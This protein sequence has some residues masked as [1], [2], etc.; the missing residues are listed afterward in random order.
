M[1]CLAREER[2]THLAP[3]RVFGFH[4]GVS[5]FELDRNSAGAPGA[6]RAMA[7]GQIKGLRVYAGVWEFLIMDLKS[8]STSLPSYNPGTENTSLCPKSF[9]LHP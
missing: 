1:G 4:A 7:L 5:E 3:I 8:R 2:S 9:V 6:S